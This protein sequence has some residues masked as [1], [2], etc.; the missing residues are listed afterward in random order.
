VPNR[1]YAASL[2]PATGNNLVHPGRFTHPVV[3]RCCPGPRAQLSSRNFGLKRL[4]RYNCQSA[5][6][7]AL[8]QR[9][10]RGRAESAIGWWLVQAGVALAQRPSPRLAGLRDRVVGDRCLKTDRP[11]IIGTGKEQDVVRF[12]VRSAFLVQEVFDEAGKLGLAA[13]GALASSRVNRTAV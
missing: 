10:F 13:G 12:A 2:G 8:D 1:D 6:C 4:G 11:Q 3:F 9:S 7:A 5:S